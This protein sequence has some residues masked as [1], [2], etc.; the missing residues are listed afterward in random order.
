MI[1]DEGSCSGSTP[2]NTPSLCIH[3]V[4]PLRGGPNLSK[5]VQAS[6]EAAFRD[7][8]QQPQQQQ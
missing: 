2:N 3:K 8:K 4:L 5:E 6:E 7:S 1:E